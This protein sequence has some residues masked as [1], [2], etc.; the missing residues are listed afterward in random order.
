MLYPAVTLLGHFFV[1]PDQN[2][3]ALAVYDVIYN[4]VG[5][6]LFY[7]FL[8]KFV[9]LLKLLVRPK[10]PDFVLHSMHV[11]VMAHVEKA[12]LAFNEDVIL[13]LRKVYMF[14]AKVMSINTEVLQDSKSSLETKYAASTRIDN[15]N[16]EQ[17]YKIILTI[18]ESLMQFVVK[19]F[20][21]H[22]DTAAEY[23]T[24]LFILREA[25]ERIVYSAKTLWDSKEE[26]LDEL[27]DVRMPL[28]DSYLRQFTREMID[29]Y[30]VVGAYLHGEETEQHRKHLQK[31][32][33]ELTNADEHFLNV[34]ADKLPQEVLSNR[35]LSALVHLS[36]ALNRSHKA[37]LHTIDLLYPEK[38]K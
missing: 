27:R 4:T 34:V 37:M 9:K 32:F 2:V 18:E 7:P 10:E 20:E 23:R 6:I 25:I 33:Q 21:K 5:A 28:I 3:I 1:L 30:V 19:L 16:L 13:L 15:D 29:M 14:N 17:D 22:K 8:G 36:Q 26:S 35:Q 31:Y 24:S 38:V 12:I 11:M